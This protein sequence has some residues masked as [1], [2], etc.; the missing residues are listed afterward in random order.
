MTG[1]RTNGHAANKAEVGSIIVGLEYQ[2]NWKVTPSVPHGTNAS[3]LLTSSCI[4]LAFNE[5]KIP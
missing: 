1:R 5:A 2:H 4:L 3:H